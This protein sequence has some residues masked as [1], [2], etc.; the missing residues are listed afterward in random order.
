MH[1]ALYFEPRKGSMLR[2]LLCPRKCLIPDG[3]TGYC[4]VR[5]NIGG[6]LYS[7]SYGHPCSIHADPIEKKPFFHVLPGTTSLSISTVGCNLECKFCQNWQISQSTPDMIDTRYTDPERIVRSAEKNGLPSITYTYGEPVVFIEYARDI[8]AAASSRQ[9]MSFAVTNGYYNSRPFRDL[10]GDIDA[11]KIDLKAFTD[12][13][14]RKICGG[15]LK[16]V[17]ESIVEARRQG[18]WLE[19]VYLMVP[20]LNDSPEEI[21]RM[22]RWLAKN[23]GREVPIHFSRFF[24]QYKLKN[25]P[26]TPLSSLEKAYGICRE[27]GMKFVY[28]GNIPGKGRES[29]YCPSCGELIIERRGYRI[30]SK[31]MKGDRCGNCGEAIP[32]IWNTG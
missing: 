16:P 8:S 6:T 28:I 20:T 9:I 13:Y 15:T 7:L 26:P 12:S 22:S 19:I 10:L 5:K 1:R 14:Y 18:V 23:A 3:K 2:C 27:E 32:G 4:G 11:V 25:L 21:R 29:T 31:D 30:I 17:L 24:P